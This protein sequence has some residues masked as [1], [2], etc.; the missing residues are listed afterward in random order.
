MFDFIKN[1]VV[2]SVFIFGG[3]ALSY[4]KYQYTFS[5]VN[6]AYKIDVVSV[7]V[8]LVLFINI[9]SIKTFIAVMKAKFGK[10]K[11]PKEA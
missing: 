8:L 5:L 2:V 4:T 9:K 7:Y 11:T 1:T 10:K 6:F 3:L